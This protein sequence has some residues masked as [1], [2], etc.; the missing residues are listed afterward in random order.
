MSVKKDEFDIRNIANVVHSWMSYI[1]EVSSTKHL[2]A[3]SS[4]R[5]P[6]VGLLERRRGTNVFMEVQHPNFEKAL[7]DFKW[8][9]EDNSSTC[10]LELKYVRD[11]SI[12]V[13][14]FF[15]DIFRLALIPEKNARKFF[16]LCGQSD[17]FKKRIQNRQLNADGEE[18]RAVTKEKQQVKFKQTNKNK[19]DKCIFD[20]ILSFDV[21]GD[22]KVAT[23]E[24][25]FMQQNDNLHGFYNKFVEAYSQKCK[26]DVLLPEKIKIKTTLMQPIDKCLL[27][28]VAVWE[29]ESI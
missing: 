8:E 5:Y 21:S 14:D 26:N 10:Y 24:F 2:A 16:L 23:K 28:A 27:S 15:D 22:G 7:I 3:E 19:Q 6:I 29:I 13:Q 12:N 9:N 11:K 1:F 25:E 4:L 17:D 20:D 18:E